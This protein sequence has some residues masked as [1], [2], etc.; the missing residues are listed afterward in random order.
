MAIELTK[1]EKSPTGF[2]AA[3][4]STDPAGEKVGGRYTGFDP[5]MTK[6]GGSGGMLLAVQDINAKVTGIAEWGQAAVL[7]IIA[8]GIGVLVNGQQVM[9][10]GM[11]LAA[12][13][14][15]ES[16][17]GIAVM[18]ESQQAMLSGM[19]LAAR[20]AALSKADVRGE[21]K[22]EGPKLSIEEKF[23]NMLQSME[24][25]FAGLSGTKKS[26]LG[27]GA[28]LAGL[29][30]MNTYA[31]E[32][33]AILAPILKFFKETLIPNLQEL[34]QIIL[35][36][37]GG[38]WTLISGA[39][40]STALWSL[41]GVSGK[42]ANLFA[43]VQAS[44]KLAFFDD[45]DFRTRAGKSWAGR[46]NKAL[47]GTKGGTGGLFNRIGGMFRG[48]GNGIR[49][50][51]Q[52][53]LDFRTK[54]AKGWGGSINRALY[55]TKGSPGTG[56]FGRIG[57]MFRSIGTSMRN[58]SLMPNFAS[59]MLNRAGTWK[60]TLSRGLWGAKGTT[61]GGVLGTL[62]NTIAKIAI[63]IKGI[64][65]PASVLGKFT[66]KIKS[67]F[68]I[69]GKALG[70]VSK[71]TGLTAFL[72][73][74]L[75]IGKAI[76]IVGQIIMVL[77]GIFSFIK[78][79]IEGFKTGGILGAIK[80]GLIGLY[81]GLVGSFLNLIA[82]II[83]WVF[84]KLGFE[85]FGEWISG[86][87]FSFDGIMNG[88]M[89]VVDQVRYLMW[90][91][92]DKILGGWNWFA[93]KVSGVWGFGWAKKVETEAF[94]PMYD[95]DVGA[96]T[97]DS[98]IAEDMPVT[99]FQTPTVT[100]V[101]MQ[102]FDANEKYQK[103]R[104]DAEAQELVVDEKSAKFVENI[105][106]QDTDAIHANADEFIAAIADTEEN[107]LRLAEKE[108]NEKKEVDELVLEQQ[109]QTELQEQKEFEEWQRQN[110]GDVSVVDSST[111]T[112]VNSRTM[113]SNPFSVDASDMV[114]ARLN[115]VIP[116]LSHAH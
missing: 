104:E 45:V 33:V 101:E 77:V 59:N 78:G 99:T 55:G 61:G 63:S 23:A 114:A 36:A 18:V 70:F 22:D 11:E 97:S 7:D 98:T 40:L 91:V 103:M 51:F 20:D 112:Q 44:I 96:E 58:S 4:G 53:N 89:W 102:G 42:I 83:G 24:D 37:P 107:E 10:S 100:H 82:D 110:G 28:L 17:D 106:T 12:R 113:V 38:Y 94:V 69:I 105:P 50:S 54:A 34:N 48:L 16:A 65:T 35:D 46:I 75:N 90:W 71:M 73:L 56:V 31:E 111:H 9:I 3:K 81:D 62:T 76:P 86:L 108:S 115:Y 116:G 84:K 95:P 1:D 8:S 57:G 25:A 85:R 27:I 32:L 2:R 13:D 93:D 41:F 5:A 15:A 66:S 6:V 43:R 30:L 14:A 79:A 88:I 68:A 109:K 39:A 64:F 29:A 80:G 47:Y 60:A 49:A 92:K 74:G 87:D 19:E 52:P 26:L 67:I 72:R 21:P